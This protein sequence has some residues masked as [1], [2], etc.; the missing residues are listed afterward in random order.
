MKVIAKGRSQVGWAKEFTCTGNGNNGG[1]CGAQ[2][3]V[4][5][6]DLF[7]TQSHFRD[8]TDSFLTFECPECRVWTDLTQAQSDAAPQTA[9]NARIRVPG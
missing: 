3:L 4:E 7:V 2:L 5:Q 9:W 1:G 8:E 6:G